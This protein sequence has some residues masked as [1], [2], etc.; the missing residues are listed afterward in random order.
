MRGLAGTTMPSLNEVQIILL[1]A[2]SNFINSENCYSIEMKQALEGHERGE[3]GVIPIILRWGL[4]EKTP[5]GKLQV[6]P[7]EGGL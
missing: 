5:L 3:A 7:T 4:W 2:S 6:L 1:L